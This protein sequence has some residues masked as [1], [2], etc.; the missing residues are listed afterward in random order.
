VLGDYLD[1]E[2]KQK[3][4]GCGAASKTRAEKRQA[5]R[6]SPCRRMIEASAPDGPQRA[7]VVARVSVDRD[8]VEQPSRPGPVERGQEAPL[9]LPETDRRI[10]GGYD[11]T[12][13]DDRR[14]ALH[15]ATQAS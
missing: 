8:G 12:T 5:L 11:Y 9:Q 7:A 13:C 6:P 10:R 4:S 3:G 15:S 1:Y 2:R 14:T